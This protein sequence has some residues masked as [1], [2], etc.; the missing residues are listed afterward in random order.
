M[1]ADAPRIAVIDDEPR[2]RELLELAL[3]HGGY[4]VRSAADGAAGLTLAKEW[5]PDLIVL[6]VMMP[7]I[8]GIA[9]LP[10]LRRITDAPIVMLSAKGEVYDR[11]EGLTAGAD[12]YLSKPFEISE[13]L[14][15][16]DAKL[17]RPHLERRSVLQYEGLTV[18]LDEHVVERDGKRLDLSPLEYK[19][20]VTLLRRPKRVYT[21]EDLLDLVWGDEADV[22]TGA[23][24]RY[25][26]YLRAK[27]DGG[28]GKTLIATIRGAGYTLRAD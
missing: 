11:V 7:K 16:I 8:D 25:I 21:R 14:A 5:S 12:D 22:G 2:I 28:F 24:E 19:L 4:V 27:V 23:V 13:L 20:L 1:T 18:D 17:R 15:H 26:S 10:M 9:L 3:G 6:D